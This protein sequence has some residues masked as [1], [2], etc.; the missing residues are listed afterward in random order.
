[1]TSTWRLGSNANL[2]YAAY[3][4]DWDK[5]LVMQSRDKGSLSS[6]AISTMDRFD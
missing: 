1:M 3:V 5:L 4:L 6:Q 2:T